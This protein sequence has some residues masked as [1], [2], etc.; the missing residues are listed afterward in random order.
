MNFYNF[1][2]IRQLLTTGF[3]REELNTLCFD[4]F[5]LRD[6]AKNNESLTSKKFFVMELINYSERRGIVN[7]LLQ[8]AK[9][10]N[11]SM[12]NRYRPY[13]NL[14]LAPEIAAEERRVLD[15]LNRFYNLDA[16]NK[17]ITLYTSRHSA[18]TQLPT[19][20]NFSFSHSDYRLP[21]NT[22]HDYQQSERQ[23]LE[24][25]TFISEQEY[26]DPFSVAS[27][28]EILEA[29]YLKDEIEK[30]RL[31][32]L[33]PEDIVEELLN[34]DVINV[35]L[36]VCP[37]P[38]RYEEILNKGTTIFIGGPRANLGTFYYL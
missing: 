25:T 16:T 20:N 5:D 10:E 1:A 8:A 24:Q 29:L 23:H 6:F 37:E 15:N 27:A 2:N 33:Y 12:Y 18:A 38:H 7:T 9:K 17:T 4:F 28:I 31:R 34:T 32:D 21:L 26:H 30:S 36:S 22:I 19:I 3:N 11:E 14:P 13:Y 35:S